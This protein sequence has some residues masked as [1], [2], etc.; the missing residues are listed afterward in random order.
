M[1][2]TTTWND[3]RR[4]ARSRGPSPV[5]AAPNWDMMMRAQQQAQAQQ[6][7]SPQ[8]RRGMFSPSAEIPASA[9]QYRNRFLQAQQQSHHQRAASFHDYHSEDSIEGLSPPLVHGGH[10]RASSFNEPNSEPALLDFKL[11]PLQVEAFHASQ[12]AMLAGGA[13]GHGGAASGGNG[14]AGQQSLSPILASPMGMLESPTNTWNSS[15]SAFMGQTAA[16]V[17]IDQYF[18]QAGPDDDNMGE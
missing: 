6:Q 12:Q 1:N 7:P 17:N 15:L 2:Q 14:T 11:T 5:Q 3:P 8:Q 9:F 16:D 10:Q 13:G 18:N 4:P